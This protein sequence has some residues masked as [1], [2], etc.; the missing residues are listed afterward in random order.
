M[1]DPELLAD[2]SVAESIVSAFLP[3]AI[4]RRIALKQLVTSADYAQAVAP[5]AWGVTLY[6]DLFR[7]NVGRVEAVVVGGG[8]IR[9]NCVGSIGTPPFVGEYFERPNYRSVPD[10]KCA[11]VGPLGVFSEVETDLQGPHREFI[12]AIGRKKSGE[13]VS[14]SVHRKSHAEGLMT[15][16]RSFLTLLEDRFVSPDEVS[17]PRLL[18]EGAVCRVTV[19]AYERNPEAR[20][21]CIA[22]YGTG[23][24]ICGFSFGEVYGPD[25][26]GYIHVHHIRPL[27]EVGREYIVDPIEDLRPV[28]PNCH[29]VLHLSD[30][31]R[32]IE[33]VRQF[34]EQQRHAEPGAA[35]DR[36]RE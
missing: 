6:R 35:A 18:A 36:P 9:L 25:A 3:N 28:C 14:G 8:F 17:P 20:R 21:R 24:C 4:E 7:L 16:A 29:A 23:C 1:S 12:E 31:C 11:F 15:Y 33:E 27:S 13:A 34:L 22:A 19:N 32:T 30:P 2:S 26:E 10:S 5:N